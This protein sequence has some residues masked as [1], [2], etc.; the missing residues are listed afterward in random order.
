[1]DFYNN[2]KLVLTIEGSRI[3]FPTGH[4]VYQ[5]IMCD[6][7][8]RIASATP[9]EEPIAFDRVQV[10][11]TLGNMELLW[12]VTSNNVTAY[13]SGRPIFTVDDRAAVWTNK[14]DFVLPFPFLSETRS[15]VKGLM[16]ATD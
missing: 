7:I 15:Y 16:D 11:E 2:G 4:F 12:M 1:M 9:V 14:F 8:S 5:P 13:S 6:L 3:T 10:T